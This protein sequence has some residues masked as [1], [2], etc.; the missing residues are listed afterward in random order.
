MEARIFY[1]KADKNGTRKS[2]VYKAKNNA[3]YYVLI[4]EKEK[5]AEIINAKRRN[6]I[7]FIQRSNYNVLRRSVKR[8]L[9]ELGVIF[10]KQLKPHMA[11][12]GKELNKKFVD[13]V[14]KKKELTTGSN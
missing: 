4:N 1:N 5:W 6:V 10:E 9:F 7:D 14:K 12:Y 3:E 13:S 2:K 11:K 8:S